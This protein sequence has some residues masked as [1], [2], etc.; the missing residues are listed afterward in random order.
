VKELCTSSVNSI[1]D[2]EQCIDN[3]W[4]TFNPKELFEDYYDGPVNSPSEKQDTNT[5]RRVNF[6]DPIANVAAAKGAASEAAEPSEGVDPIISEGAA[7]LTPPMLPKILQPIHNWRSRRLPKPVSRLVAAC[8]ALLVIPH[9]CN[10]IVISLKY[11]LLQPR[12]LTKTP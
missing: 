12:K 2:E 10:P 6:A 7:S 1:I 8:L 11:G 3:L 4:P 9:H 5:E